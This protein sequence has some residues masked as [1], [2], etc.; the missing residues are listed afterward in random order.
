MGHVEHKHKAPK[1]VTCA[2]I[3]I[4][5]T[6]TEDQDTSGKAIVELLNTAGHKPIYKGVIKD[7]L[8]TIKNQLD[9]AI[10]S[11]EIQAIIFD[12]GTGVGFRDVTIESI[13]P[14]LDKTLPGF[15][16]ILRQLSYDDIG[17]AAMMSRSL[18]GVIAGKPVFCL[19]GSEN[20]CRLAVEKLI[21]PELGHLILEVSK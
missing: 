17:S 10:K 13:E 9:T 19:P 14:H 3:T 4:S 8:Q 12:G 5:D 15:G 1:N 2:V 21:A 16:E 20:A 18:A 7:D 11:D 6:R